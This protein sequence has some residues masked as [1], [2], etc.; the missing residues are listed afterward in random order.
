MSRRGAGV[1]SRL[2]AVVAGVRGARAQDRRGRIRSPEALSE[3][4]DEARSHAF[5]RLQTCHAAARELIA[6]AAWNANLEWILTTRNNARPYPDALDTEMI[7]RMEFLLLD[8]MVTLDSASTGAAV[9][10]VFD[11]ATGES[12]DRDFAAQGL[13]AASDNFL[14]V[15]RGPVSV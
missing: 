6:P 12:Q 1:W 15:F 5:A 2:A 11:R 14:A 7:D 9:E 8:F 13:R 10:D 3:R 4:A